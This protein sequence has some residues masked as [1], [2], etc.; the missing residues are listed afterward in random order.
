MPEDLKAMHVEGCF[1]CLQRSGTLENDR[2]L[3]DEVRCCMGTNLYDCV[4]ITHQACTC[5]HRLRH[6]KENI[7]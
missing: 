1:L 2:W 5:I 3:L 7:A 4:G 6:Y